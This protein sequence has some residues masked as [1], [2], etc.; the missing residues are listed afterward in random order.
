VAITT[1]DKQQNINHM[2]THNAEQMAAATR[3]LFIKPR[4]S[5]LCR[6]LQSSAAAQYA[7][8]LMSSSSKVGRQAGAEAVA[9][10]TQPL[11][12]AHLM[13]AYTEATN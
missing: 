7:Q 10:P 4:C 8:R 13:V 3:Q 6:Q 9:L 1:H 12:V 2:L 5:H 11:V